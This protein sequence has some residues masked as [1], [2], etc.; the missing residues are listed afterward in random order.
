[1]K[2]WT[3]VVAVVLAIGVFA[4]VFAAVRGAA[5][6]CVNGVK[7]NGIGQCFCLDRSGK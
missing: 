2:N 5:A 4:A 1:M 7:C 6:P 3:T